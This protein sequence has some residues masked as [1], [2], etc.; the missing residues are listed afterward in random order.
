MWRKIFIGF[1]VLMALPAVGKVTLQTGGSGEA[2][3]KDEDLL[4]CIRGSAVELATY[5]GGDWAVVWLDCAN[6]FTINEVTE[7][8]FRYYHLQYNDLAGP[9]MVLALE[10]Y[11]L[12]TG[13]LVH[14]LPS[15]TMLLS[16][17]L[18]APPSTPLFGAT[19]PGMEPI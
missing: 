7:L 6:K 19:A 2:E 13:Q 5:F 8:G 10:K 14:Y 11:N 4:V 12:T 16:R 9:R 18:V 15:V 17:R 1:L 3:W